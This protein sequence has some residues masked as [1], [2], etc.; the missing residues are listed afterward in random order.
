MSNYIDPLAKKGRDQRRTRAIKERDRK[1]Y[2]VPTLPELIE[3]NKLL[4]IAWTKEGKIKPAM[5]M[6]EKIDRLEKILE[7]TEEKQYEN[8]L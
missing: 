1:K 3:K 5:G 2:G 8:C 4:V 7:R 6:G